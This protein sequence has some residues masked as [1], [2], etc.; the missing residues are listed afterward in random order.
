MSVMESKNHIILTALGADQ[1][2]IVSK[3]SKAVY[4][5]ACDI[6][7]SRMI[8][9]GGEFALMVQVTGP[10]N[11]VAKLE[12]AL[13]GLEQSLGMV[14][15]TKQT[16]VKKR[17]R[18]VVPYEIEVVSLDH[19][20]IVYQL[21]NYLSSRQINIEELSTET[22]SAPHTGSPMFSVKIIV[23]LPSSV[24]LAEFKDNFLDYC[25]ELNLDAL[26]EPFKT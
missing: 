26:I 11:N 15:Q 5:C 17:Q 6:V 12:T 14:I 13:K 18:D 20:G 25:D 8:A 21:A 19:P 2:G 16:T 1:P 3:I 7:D 4:D 24:S 9:L 23:G 22:Y 10:W